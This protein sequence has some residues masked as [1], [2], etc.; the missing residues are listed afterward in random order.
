MDG[1][2]DRIALPL[3]QALHMEIARVPSAVTRCHQ[4]VVFGVVVLYIIIIIIIII[5]IIIII[6]M[7]R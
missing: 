6:I 1:Q 2:S 5:T 4:S 3:L 7:L